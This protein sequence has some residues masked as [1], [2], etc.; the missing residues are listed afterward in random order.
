MHRADY[1]LKIAVSDGVRVGSTEHPVNASLKGA[2]ELRLSDLTVGGPIPSTSVPSRPTVDD[3]VHFGAVHGYLETYGAAAPRT[4]V[5]YEVA[6]GDDAPALLGGDAV[7]RRVNESRVSFSSIMPVNALPPGRYQLRASI[8]VDGTPATT[9][10]RGFDIARADLVAAAS[11]A[12]VP[13]T[14]AGTPVVSPALTALDAGVEMFLP[15]E[16]GDLAAPFQLAE[17]LAPDTLRTFADRVPAA[18]KASL[19]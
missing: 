15:I 16:A 18:T 4:T 12:P 9:L 10:T 14:L 3:T 5:R 2:G 19:R 13:G 8:S 1:V 11:P 6:A 17:A 7:V